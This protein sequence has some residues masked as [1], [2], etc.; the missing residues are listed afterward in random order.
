MTGE[1]CKTCAFDRLAELPDDDLIAAVERCGA[2]PRL[3][4]PGERALFERLRLAV[5]QARQA[6][7]LAGKRERELAELR[8]TTLR[9]E[10]RLSRL[11]LVH[12]V[13]SRELEVKSRILAMLSSIASAANA[14]QSLLEILHMCL[15]PLCTGLKM[16]CGIAT[17][18]QERGMH[19]VAASLDAEALGAALAALAGSPWF[20]AIS[21]EDVP[22]V[23]ELDDP[24]WPGE[25]RERALAA[26]LRR[27]ISL[28]VVVEGE[29]LGGCVLFSAEPAPRDPTAELQ[30]VTAA[31]DALAV[32]LS[33]VAARERAAAA[34]VRAREAAEGANR[35][36]S[37]FVSSM[38]HEL[39]TP[40][41]AILGFCELLVEELTEE[42]LD[43]QA[44][45][46]VKM[47]RAGRHLSGLINNILDLSKIEAGKM[48]VVIETVDLAELV[49][50][51]LTTLAPLAEASDTQISIL[52]DQPLPRVQADSTKVR[53]ILFNLV[54]N[55]TK[56]TRGGRVTVH[57]DVCVE[58]ETRLLRL[59]I[60]DN[61]I[62]MTEEQLGRIFQ[63]FT[64]ANPEIASRYG[65]TGLGLTLCR[66]LTALLGGTIT[67]TSAPQAGSRFVVE[68]PLP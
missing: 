35:A 25:W 61:G 21:R 27:A 55:A 28:P 5:H 53:Q 63:P 22:G 37:D 14:S 42:G 16:A 33:R 17:I 10:D 36:K 38:S 15:R 19:F 43:E 4:S 29:R 34:N 9:S 68:L 41:N 3:G 45:L 13:S 1:P 44:A 8:R 52:G 12:Q 66:H 39:R 47:G 7:N 59:A 2:C 40:L 31:Y 23:F 46:A 57:V 67:A 26:G 30:F 62:G 51:V 60:A 65:G 24:R 18:G 6:R 56:F 20:A 11:E 54:G 64:Q 32:Q 48:D 49:D 58:G 50:D